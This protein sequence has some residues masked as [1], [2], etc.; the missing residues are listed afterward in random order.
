MSSAADE[1]VV[2][3][4]EP[5]AVTNHEHVEESCAE[6]LAQVQAF[7]HN[8]L[9]I[10]D[11]DLIRAHLNACE[12]CLENFDVEALIS[13]M[14]RRSCSSPPAP[15]NLRVRL[16]ALRVTYRLDDH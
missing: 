16:T 4:P 14:L 11:A 9:P 13:R 12:K 2:P 7:L 5:R 3:A 15:P 6:A 10:S 8:E 1:P